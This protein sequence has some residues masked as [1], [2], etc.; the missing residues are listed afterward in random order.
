MIHLW[1]KKGNR[2][3]QVL[4]I[5]DPKRKEIDKEDV[6]AFIY[7]MKAAGIT[8]KSPKEFHTLLGIVIQIGIRNI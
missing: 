1:I 4:E 5:E 8:Q 7:E 3:C 2:F 6:L